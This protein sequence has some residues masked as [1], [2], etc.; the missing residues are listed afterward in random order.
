MEGDT[1]IA[2]SNW[3]Q[4][5]WVAVSWSSDRTAAVGDLSLVAANWSQRAKVQ[6]YFVSDLQNEVGKYCHPGSANYK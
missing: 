3:K 6:L 1:A 2:V 5:N 4:L